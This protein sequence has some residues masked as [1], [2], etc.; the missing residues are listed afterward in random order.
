MGREISLFPISYFVPRPLKTMGILKL[1][2]IGFDLTSSATK[3]SSVCFIVHLCCRNRCLNPQHM[4]LK[5]IRNKHE[6]ISLI[7]PFYFFFF[8]S[9]E[10]IIQSSK[11]IKNTN[12]LLSCFSPSPL[13]LLLAFFFPSSFCLQA[14][15]NVRMGH[16]RLDRAF[17]QCDPP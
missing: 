3:T 13:F 7:S 4:F 5:H 1:I 15:G 11:S 14:T 12:K 8:F 2:L 6:R 9:Q 10:V 17:S 16:F